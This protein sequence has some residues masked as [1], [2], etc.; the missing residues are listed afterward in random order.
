[1]LVG[2]CQLFVS[3]VAALYGRHLPLVNRV[4]PYNASELYFDPLVTIFPEFVFTN[5]FPIKMHG[6]LI[7]QPAVG[8]WVAVV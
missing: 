4:A 8:G 2:G 3:R 6:T 1:M 7:L 5:H